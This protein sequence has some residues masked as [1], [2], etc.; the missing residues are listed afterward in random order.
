MGIWD[1]ICSKTDSIKRNAPDRSRAAV[2]KIHDKLQPHLPD[3]ETRF[4]IAAD[5]LINSARFAFFE[6]VKIVPGG[7]IVYNIVSQSQSHSVSGKKISKE[8]TEEL[9]E[10]KDKVK[11]LEK[12]LSDS[13][14]SVEKLK[15][16][17]KKLEKELRDS[18]K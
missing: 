2:L 12:E 5:L 4:K 6:G 16:K 3:E 18:K 13:K 14:K 10:L 15:D 11:K 7:S 17:V 1:D 9:K 8:H